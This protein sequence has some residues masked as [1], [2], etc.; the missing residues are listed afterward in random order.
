[1]HPA[2]I[3]QVILWTGKLENHSACQRQVN[4]TVSRASSTAAGQ[5]VSELSQSVAHSVVKPVNQTVCQFLANL[6]AI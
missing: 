3:E 1:M 2:D 5:P 6:T 4:E